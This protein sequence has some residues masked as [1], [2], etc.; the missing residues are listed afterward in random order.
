MNN[1]NVEALIEEAR[2]ILYDKTRTTPTRPLSQVVTKL[3]EALL[4][5]GKQRAD[6]AK[7]KTESQEPIVHVCDGDQK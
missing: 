2:A 6:E 1:H 4:W 3:D 7:A 5:L